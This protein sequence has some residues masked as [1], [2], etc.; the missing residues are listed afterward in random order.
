MI[1][2]IFQ[3]PYIIGID[4]CDHYWLYTPLLITLLLLQMF[5]FYLLVRIARRKYKGKGFADV[6]EKNQGRNRRGRRSS[7][8]APVASSPPA[9]PHRQY[10]H[11]PAA[12]PLTAILTA[13]PRTTSASTSTAA[14]TT[15][16]LTHTPPTSP[17]TSKLPTVTTP[18][19]LALSPGTT[20][21]KTR[22]AT[23]GH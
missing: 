3:A 18:T 1:P 14:A 21:P 7:M 22:S 8:N 6:R 10:I 15:T 11:S 9:T 16:T 23:L 12:T 4:N 2:S 13:T 5:W 19:T 17:K 20:R